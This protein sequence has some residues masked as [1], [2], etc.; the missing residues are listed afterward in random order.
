MSQKGQASEFFVS[1]QGTEVMIQQPHK[2]SADTS[3]R[4]FSKSLAAALACVSI[5]F[6][7]EK[8]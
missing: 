7:L 4:F 3:S 6:K 1:I 5:T 8:K 2:H